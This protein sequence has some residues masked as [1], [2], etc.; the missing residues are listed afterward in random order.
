MDRAASVPTVLAQI[1]DP[2]IRLD[3][4]GASAAALSA[5]VAAVLDLETSADAVVVT[6]DL[7]NDGGAPEYALVQELL[8]PFE[9][10]VHVLAG[11]HDDR[12]MLRAVF[13]LEADAEPGAPYDYSASVGEMLLIGLDST[14]PGVTEGALD[15]AQL[16]WLSDRLKAA[17]DTTTVIAIHH[18]PIR[19][20]NKAIDSIGLAGL[21]RSRL[22]DLLAQHPQVRRVISGHVHATTF[23]TLAGCPV[24]ACAA[25]RFQLPFALP[26]GDDL[27]LVDEPGSM[28]LHVLTGGSLKTHVRALP[29]AS[30]QP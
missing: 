27:V 1:T 22:A 21:D 24:V 13:P 5:A 23:D 20:G 28:A 7:V 11:N 17:P 16:R 26:G 6:G 18:P 14:I 10:P 15:E 8:A 19:T 25:T 4:D 2:H 9:V 29:G 3:D 12:A 30:R